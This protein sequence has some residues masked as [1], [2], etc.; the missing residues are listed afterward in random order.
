MLTWNPFGIVQIE[1]NTFR[2]FLGV[3]TGGGPGGFLNIENFRKFLNHPVL[4]IRSGSLSKQS[5]VQSHHE[6]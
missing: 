6:T 4:A 1:N 5:N 3:A 2:K